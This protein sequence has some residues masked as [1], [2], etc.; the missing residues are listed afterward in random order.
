M[1]ASCIPGKFQ[2]LPKAIFADFK[3]MQEENLNTFWR[4][5]AA[6]QIPSEEE[7]KCSLK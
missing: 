5:E 6:K 2:E 1:R 7:G 4:Y 3:S